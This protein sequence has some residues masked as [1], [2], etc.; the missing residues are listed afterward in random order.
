MRRRFMWLLP[1]LSISASVNAG[2]ANG[3]DAQSLKELQRTKAGAVEVVLLST[4]GALRHGKDSF[5][6]EFRS[7]QDQHLVDA[8]TVTINAT[9]TMAGMPPMIGNI[10]ATRT[11]VG[12]YA[13]DSDLNMVGSWRLGLEWDGPAGKGS[14]TLPGNVQ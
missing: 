14:A 5:V 6:V 9:M 13:V 2:C 1:V 8:G 3:Q 12:R 7:A 4:R 11:D 10:N